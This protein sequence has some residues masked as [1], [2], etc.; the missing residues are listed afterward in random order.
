MSYL[1]RFHFQ[2]LG[3]EQGPKLVFLHGLM[4]SLA[5]WKPTARAFENKYQILLYD[6]RG[7]GRS[8]QPDSGFRPE[9]YA[10][11]LERILDEL[12]WEEINLVGHSMGGRNAICFAA[13][14]MHRVNKLVVEDIGPNADPARI[15]QI[16]RLLQGVPLPFE[17]RFVARDFFRGE[18]L[19]KFSQE[20]NIQALA[21]YLHSNLKA[22]DRGEMVWKFSSKAILETMEAGRSRDYWTQWRKISAPSLLLRGEHSR[23]LPPSIY[24]QMLD[25]N[26]RAQGRVIRGA[27][28]WI[29]SEQLESFT[30]SLQDFFSRDFFS[31]KFLNL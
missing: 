30:Q 9:D 3:K 4:G 15:Q 7:H 26:P 28:H 6:Q 25:E 31:K 12:A 8:F 14:N 18:F 27:G 24:E 16:H 23:E 11:D 19:E 1:N 2:L 20:P 17:N 22:N 13:R 5:N 21:K 29:H 10:E